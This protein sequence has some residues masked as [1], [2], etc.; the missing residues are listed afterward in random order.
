MKAK[1]RKKIDLSRSK[2]SND[3]GAER[4]ILINSLGTETSN[5][6]SP[7]NS[8]SSDVYFNPLFESSY[9]DSYLSEKKN[10]FPKNILDS[11][12]FFMFLRKK[13]II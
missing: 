3:K 7:S 4:P 8:D 1:K 11:I 12:F 10:I 13:N 9:S 2:N 5:S 6:N